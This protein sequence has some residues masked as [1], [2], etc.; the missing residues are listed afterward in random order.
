MRYHTDYELL[1]YNNC[2]N[3][4]PIHVC[5]NKCININAKIRYCKMKV[6]LKDCYYY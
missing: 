6:K 1:K 2:M 3:K 5:K 4:N